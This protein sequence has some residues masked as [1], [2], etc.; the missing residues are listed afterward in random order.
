MN[1]LG[2]IELRPKTG[3]EPF[4]A[5]GT[6]AGFELLEFWRWSGSDLVANTTRGILAEFIV[7]KALGIDTGRPREPWA[8]YDLTWP[9]AD[10]VDLA[11][12]VKSSGYIQSWSQRRLSTIQFLVPARRP[13][14][15]S[16]G[17][18]EAT[19]RRS[20]HVYVFALLAHKDQ[21]TIDPLQLDQ[22]EFHVLATQVLDERKRSQ[23]SVTLNSL[24]DLAG[25]AVSFSA[26]REAVR[27]AGVEAGV[28]PA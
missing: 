5:D 19:P 13:Y 10:G 6:A 25:P 4:I 28:I 23:H 12:E 18:L 7:A 21:R 27:G 3:A 15:E 16:T 26:L 24:R 11:I 22:W 1:D 20:A 17:E 2:P 9:V 14:D 8:A